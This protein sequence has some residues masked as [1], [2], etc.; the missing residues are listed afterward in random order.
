M[1]T[2]DMWLKDYLA[3]MASVEGRIIT[4]YPSTSPSALPP[5]IRVFH[6]EPTFHAK[7]FHWSDSSNQALKQKSLGGQ[8]IMVS[9]FVDKVSSYLRYGN[10]EAR[11]YVSGASN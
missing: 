6:D 5:I 2:R 8:A 4:E 10:E 7:S 11:L 3:T 9:D 1:A